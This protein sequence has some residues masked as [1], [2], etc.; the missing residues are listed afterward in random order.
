MIYC[1]FQLGG[2]FARKIAQHSFSYA[3]HFFAQISSPSEIFVTN[4]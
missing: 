1:K 4:P 2:I 3:A